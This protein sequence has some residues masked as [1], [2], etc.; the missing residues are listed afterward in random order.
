MQAVRNSIVI[1]GV[2]LVVLTGCKRKLPEIPQANEDHTL[3]LTASQMAGSWVGETR[4]GYP[5]QIDIEKL[6]NLAM[7]TQL[8]FNL[9]MQVARM[10]MEKPVVT[11]DRASVVVSN[12]AFEFRT[13]AFDTPLV[14][15]NW[16]G[17]VTNMAR[18]RVHSHF[19]AE[20]ELKGTIE[21]SVFV[22]MKFVGGTSHFTLQKTDK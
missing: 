9:R 5:V 8:T 20:N 17:T 7:V 22:G 21:G 6:D 3:S 1:A 15:T 12:L 11:P 16:S 14:G 18:F 13:P 2:L 4:Q 19:A 10:S